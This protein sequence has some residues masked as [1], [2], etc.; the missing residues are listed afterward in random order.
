MDA[1]PPDEV[2]AF[3]EQSARWRDF[4]GTE[5]EPV[6]PE[7]DDRQMSLTDDATERAEE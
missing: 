7:E 6:E 3:E 1:I 2:A 5:T 4:L